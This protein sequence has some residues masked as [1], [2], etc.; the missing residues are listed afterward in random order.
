MILSCLTQILCN[1]FDAAVAAVVLWEDSVAHD[2][3]LLLHGAAEDDAD[4]EDEDSESHPEGGIVVLESATAVC[5]VGAKMIDLYQ[6]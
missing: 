4:G 5:A 3:L 6:N 1:N 2:A